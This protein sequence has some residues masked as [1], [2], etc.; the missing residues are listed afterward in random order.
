MMSVKNA[1]MGWT[2]RIADKVVR[3]L[4]GRSKVPVCEE[5]KDLAGKIVLLVAVPVQKCA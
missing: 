4:V 3:V 1:A 5:E 2:T